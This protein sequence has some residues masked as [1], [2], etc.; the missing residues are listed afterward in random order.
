MTNDELVLDEKAM[1]K[2]LFH[3]CVNGVPRARVFGPDGKRNWVFWKLS[4]YVVALLE[5][6][7][8]SVKRCINGKWRDCDDWRQLTH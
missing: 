1:P 8:V 7:S 2:W 3:V 4:Q 5:E 6:G